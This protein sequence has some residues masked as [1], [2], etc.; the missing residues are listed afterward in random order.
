MFN[1][2]II[3]NKN[4]GVILY[5]DEPINAQDDKLYIYDKNLNCTY[6]YWELSHLLKESERNGFKNNLEEYIKQKIISEYENV[7]TINDLLNLLNI[8][9]IKVEYIY[10][11]SKE[12]ADENEKYI[13][14]N[15]NKYYLYK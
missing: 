6:K 7:E 5:M 13:I 12:F 4:L 15:N 1:Y 14:L 3:E 9:Y 11:A 2:F 10:D 8:N